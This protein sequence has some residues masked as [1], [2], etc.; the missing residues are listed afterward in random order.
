MKLILSVEALSMQLTGIGRY[1]WQLT[2][3]L[4][5]VLPEASIRY[6]YQQRWAQDPERLLYEPVEQALAVKAKENALPTRKMPWGLRRI[7]KWLAKPKRVSKPNWRKQCRGAV[8]HG[9]NFFV[10]DYADKA[11]I[12]VHD[13]SVF[14]FPETHPKERIAQFNRDFERSLAKASH[15][16]T[17]SAATRRELAAYAGLSPQ[18][19]TAIS[20]AA[21]ADYRP[22]AADSVQ[23]CLSRHG[24]FYQQYA[25]CVSTL[26]PRKKIDN[27]LT[28]YRLLPA[29]LRRRCPLVLVG[30]KGWL[31]DALHHEIDKATAEG[32][33]K[34][35]GFIAEADLPLLYAGARAFA[36][37][38]L[39]EGFGLPVLEAM[40]SGVPVVASNRTSLPEVTQ[41][42]AL[43][44]EPDDV[45]ALKDALHQSLKD[46]DWR[47][48]IIPQALAVA[49]SYSW[50]RCIN[51][52]VAVYRQLDAK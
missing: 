40:A 52:T 9:P 14:K 5:E 13:L 6:H 36:Y 28:A 30:G 23:D 10:P 12:T 18:Q 20:L 8:F 24:L 47:N 48:A 31:S 49:G 2:S 35:L 3:G 41:G 45:D 22:R 26:E 42:K 7:S 50:N 37:P 17:D 32:W 34:Y 33:L 39:Y 21:G 1:A 29:P 11:V 38:S 15:I 46:D 16:I 44:V 25:L 4:P 27:L 51:E 43:H 19:V